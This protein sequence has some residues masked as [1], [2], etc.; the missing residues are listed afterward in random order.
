MMPAS[1]GWRCDVIS[2]EEEQRRFIERFVNT[3][4]VQSE[5]A[6]HKKADRRK[7]T[8]LAAAMYEAVIQ[9]EIDR[10]RKPLGQLEEKR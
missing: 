9:M 6:G 5:L 4:D 7:M 8:I 1:V 2:R 10:M 3:V